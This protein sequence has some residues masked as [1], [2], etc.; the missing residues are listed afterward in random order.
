[1]QIKRE[2]KKIKGKKKKMINKQLNMNFLKL[3]CYSSILS[4]NVI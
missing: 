3:D 1:M 4:D 2:K